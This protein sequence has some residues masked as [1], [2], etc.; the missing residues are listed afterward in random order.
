MSATGTDEA[1]RNSHVGIASALIG[2]MPMPI[3]L[4]IIAGAVVTIVATVP[5]PEPNRA[6][7]ARELEGGLEPAAS[8]RFKRRE[9]PTG[10]RS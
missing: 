2:A 8:R 5:L 7:V 9:A 1:L 10:V 3:A 4:Y 6:A